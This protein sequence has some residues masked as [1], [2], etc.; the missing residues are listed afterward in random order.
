MIF[1]MDSCALI[2]LIKSESESAALRA[3]MKGLGAEDAMATSELTELE[4][5]RTLTRHGY[6]AEEASERV[7]STLDLLG[8]VEYTRVVLR[9]AI[10]YR[11]QRL[12]T[13]DSIHLATA[14]LFRFQLGAFVTYDKELTAAAEH[15]G[16]QVIAP[17]AA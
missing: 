12:G 10:S 3:W 11:I 4:L 13:L 14:E 8:V 16:L 6:S 7:N 9:T 5:T 2:K 1:Y 17:G 15:Q